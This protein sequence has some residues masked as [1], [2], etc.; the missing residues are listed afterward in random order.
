MIFQIATSIK[1]VYSTAIMKKNNVKIVLVTAAV[2]LLLPLL[3]S[4]FYFEIDRNQTNL[5]KIRRGMTKE[6]VIE[7]MG[8]PITGEAYCNDKVFYYYTRQ[9]WM[10]GLV[11]RDEC[12]PIAFDDNDRVR[13]W[14]QDFNTGLY[15]FNVGR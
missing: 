12:T 5:A 2:S 15:E 14:G 4:C 7:I 8:Q 9:V 6:K 13:G 11:T 3:S 10:D 1:Q